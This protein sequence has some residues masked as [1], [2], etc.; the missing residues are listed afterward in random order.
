[1]LPHSIFTDINMN[2]IHCHTGSEWTPSWLAKLK[3]HRSHAFNVSYIKIM[4]FFTKKRITSE[5]S[6]LDHQV[7]LLLQG[8]LLKHVTMP[9]L[10]RKV[11]YWNVFNKLGQ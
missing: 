1:M 8:N 3:S 10:A 5:I 2:L 6:L 7:L 4:S 9:R 11:Q